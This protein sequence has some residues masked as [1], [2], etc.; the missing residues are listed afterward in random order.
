MDECAV[1]NASPLIFFSRGGHWNLL[2]SMARRILIPQAVADEIVARG[3]QDPTARQLQRERQAQVIPTA[4]I[5]LA[6]ERW[7]LGTGE[8]AV[9]ALACVTPDAVVVMDDLAGRKCAAS[10]GLLVRGTLGIVLLA[11]KR[12]MISAARPV[13][14]DMLRTG[15]YLSKPVLDSALAR[16]G[17]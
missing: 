1:V 7:G 10:C 4:Q 3:P 6:V 16:V 15:L 13:I 12:G 9:I 8:S 11:K 5:P 2:V 14:D 17:E